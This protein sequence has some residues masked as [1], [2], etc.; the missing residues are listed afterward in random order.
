MDDPDASDRAAGHRRADRRPARR[1]W[2]RRRGRPGARRGAGP[3][4]RRPL[5]RRHRADPRDRPR[6]GPPRRRGARRARRGR[7]G[8]EPAAGARPA[9]L[10]R[11]RRASSRRWRASVPTSARTAATS[12]CSTSARTGV[13]RL[14][15]L[16]SCDGCPSSSVTLKLAVEGA[17]EAAAPEV[18]THRGRGRAAPTPRA[19]GRDP[20]RRRC[21]RGSTDPAADRPEPAPGQPVPELADLA[22]GRGHACR[23]RRHRG[24]GLPARLRPVRLPRPRARAATRRCA[25]PPCPAGWVPPSARRCCAAR[26]AR[27]TTTYAGP[28]PASTTTALHLTPVPLLTDGGISSVA[29][30][31]PVSA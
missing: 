12:S 3:A 29:V 9:P 8:R 11:R 16:G 22:A 10:R 24:A 28:G 14:R 18:T 13:V 17:I 6:R 5:R 15:L 31:A 27:P 7:P 25:A 1:Q 26:A 19:D 23:R 30:A 21:G 2:R 20:G 4:R